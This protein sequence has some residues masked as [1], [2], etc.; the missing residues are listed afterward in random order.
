HLATRLGA[1]VAIAGV[2][3][4]LLALSPAFVVYG[5]WLHYEMPS[6]L[7]LSLS[8]AAL[9]ALL[10]S[11]RARW[12]HIFAWLAAALMMTRAV[13]HPLWFVLALALVGA[14]ARPVVR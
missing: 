4:A 7:L 8:A 2:A 14:T 3:C 5:H 6:A 12:A 9:G 1:P 11:E 13:Y 10:A